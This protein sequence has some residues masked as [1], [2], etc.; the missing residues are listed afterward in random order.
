MNDE[1][2]DSLRAKAEQAVSAVTQVP[3]DGG[4][5]AVGAQPW[6]PSLVLWLTISI[7]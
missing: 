4:V 5:S 6:T 1:D 3:S 2:L 7:Q